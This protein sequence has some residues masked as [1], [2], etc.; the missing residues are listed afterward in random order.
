MFTK[1]LAVATA[2]VF[3]A[4]GVVAADCT[5]TY[6]VK[7]G[8]YCDK[9]SRENQVSTFQ[10][11]AVNSG[12]Y[13][14][15]CTDLAVGSVLCLGTAGEDCKDTYTVKEGDTCDGVTSASGMNS[16]ILYLNNPQINKDCTNIYIGEVLCVAKAVQ[17]PPVPPKGVVVPPTGPPATKGP[18]TP[19]IPPPITVTGKDGPTPTTPTYSPTPVVADP[20]DDDNLPFCDEI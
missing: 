5:R 10:L 19:E 3:A 6:T 15:Q 1:I 20:S 12:K 7:E 13:N 2:V 8:D 11:A 18:D 4:Q 14:E 9:I 16:T 17:V